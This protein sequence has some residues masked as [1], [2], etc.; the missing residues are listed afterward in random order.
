MKLFYILAGL[1]ILIS[2]PFASKA[3]EEVTYSF[4]VGMPK[5]I[6]EYIATYDEW[7][8]FSKHATSGYGISNLMSIET[9]R[10]TVKSYGTSLES[11]FRTQSVSSATA[12]KSTDPGF[13][14]IFR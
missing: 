14:L 2:L 6:P 9:G 8:A 10:I 5:N 11:R 12:L 4:F 1:S 7:V 3:D 13:M